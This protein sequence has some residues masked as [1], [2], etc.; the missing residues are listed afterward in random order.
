MAITVEV[1]VKNGTKALKVF[2]LKQ[3]AEPTE[4]KNGGKTLAHFQP[5]ADNKV[6]Q[7]FSKLY[8]DTE[9]LKK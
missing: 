5:E 6:I 4:K 9:G 1:H 8:I 7:P 2:Q 3:T